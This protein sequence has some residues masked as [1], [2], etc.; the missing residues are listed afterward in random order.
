MEGGAPEE[1]G[2]GAREEGERE[3]VETTAGSEALG[4]NGMRKLIMVRDRHLYG[5]D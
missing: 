3:E 1:D 4:E 5:G 2:G